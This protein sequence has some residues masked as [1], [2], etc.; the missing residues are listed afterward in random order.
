[1]L[2]G[3]FM[4][5]YHNMNVKHGN[6]TREDF[7]KLSFDKLQV[8]ERPM[9]FKEVKEMLGSRIKKDGKQ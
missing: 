5:F 3:D 6:K 2:T 7:Y 8:D 9:T 4:A 1:M